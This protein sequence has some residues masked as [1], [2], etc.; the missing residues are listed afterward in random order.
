M[1][2]WPSQILDSKSLAS[3]SGR[4]P[5]TCHCFLLKQLACQVWLCVCGLYMF[6]YVCAFM[7]VYFHETYSLTSEVLSFFSASGLLP[8]LATH[9]FGYAGL[10]NSP[11]DPLIWLSRL[12]KQSQGSTSLHVTPPPSATIQMF[13]TTTGILSV[14]GIQTQI[15]MFARQANFTDWPISL[16]QALFFAELALIICSGTKYCQGGSYVLT[17]MFP[18]SDLPCLGVV[19]GTTSIYTIY[20]DS[21]FDS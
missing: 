1:T 21:H 7:C 8:E 3:V 6:L 11:I 5:P 12:A 13:T 10:P 14:L 18:P 9:W 19:L 2:L 20:F 15:P 16:A 4:R 17:S